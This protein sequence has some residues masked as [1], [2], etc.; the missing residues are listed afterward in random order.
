[1]TK[2]GSFSASKVGQSRGKCDPN[3]DFF[4]SSFRSFF[5]DSVLKSLKNANAMQT[6]CKCNA[7]PIYFTFYLICVFLEKGSGEKLLFF[8]QYLN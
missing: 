1:M 6:Q 5:I 4:G 7:K 8:S 3:Q 2:T